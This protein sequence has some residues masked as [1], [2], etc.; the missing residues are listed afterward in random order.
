[1]AAIAVLVV[2]PAAWWAG[3]LT[4]APA[5]MTAESATGPAAATFTP[6]PAVAPSGSTTTT[7]RRKSALAAAARAVALIGS[8]HL[9]STDGR[10]WLA[11]VLAAPTHRMQLRTLLEREASAPTMVALRDDAERGLRYGF[12]TVPVALRAEQ[13][14]TRR[15]VVSVFAALYLVSSSQPATLG[16]GLIR[17][18]LTW[19]ALGWRVQ[20]YRNSPAIGPVPAGYAPP[21]G[22]W[23]PI[24]GDNVILLSEQLREL[25]SDSV[26]PDYAPS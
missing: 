4:A 14:D 15:A 17:V 22:G 26:A 20:Y 24:N 9:L 25:L 13:V 10:T 8:P 7:T 23:Q 12:R 3:R 18:E 5:P 2:L 1:M 21:D 11:Q 6:P 19:S 16:H